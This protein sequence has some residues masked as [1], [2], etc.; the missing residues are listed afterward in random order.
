[1]TIFSWI[2]LPGKIDT[3]FFINISI[4]KH[5]WAP[6][7]S[8]H[9]IVCFIM[10]KYYNRLCWISKSI[11]W[12][13]FSYFVAYLMVHFKSSCW[14]KISD[15]CSFNHYNSHKW[16]HKAKFFADSDIGLYVE[17]YQSKVS[18]FHLMLFFRRLTK[19][20]IKC[21]K[22]EGSKTIFRDFNHLSDLGG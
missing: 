10:L 13:K 9:F 3:M 18:C 22:K 7:F 4:N 11:F 12:V 20:K 2:I 19:I 8:N 15:F 6:H 1:M 17:K 5:W 16:G 14:A 21:L